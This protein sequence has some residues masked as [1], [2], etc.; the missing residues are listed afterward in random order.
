MTSVK[1]NSEEMSPVAV[2]MSPGETQCLCLRGWIFIFCSAACCSRNW[3]R[4]LCLRGHVIS[5]SKTLLCD[6]LAEYSGNPSNLVVMSFVKILL[7]FCSPA[8]NFRSK[9]NSLYK[10]WE[11]SENIKAKTVQPWSYHRDMNA[12]RILVS[13]SCQLLYSVWVSIFIMF[14]ILETWL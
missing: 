6:A 10:M 1:A 9:S 4:P 7:L 14:L 12:S 5:G 13:V 8:S 2:R 11:I 3:V